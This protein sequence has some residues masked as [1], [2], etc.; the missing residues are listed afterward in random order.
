MKKPLLLL[1]LCLALLCGCGRSH[2]VLHFSLPPG[3]GSEP[4]FSAQQLCPKKSS[5]RISAAAGIAQA[6]VILV[7]VTG[8][9]QQIGPLTV[10]QRQPIEVAAE[11]GVW[12][13]IGLAMANNAKGPVA[14]EL[15]LDNVDLRIE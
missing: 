2:H 13:H 1:C 4:V 8:N 9:G 15:Y 7:P 10:T 6:E 3:D 12:Y 11:K 5:V 14:A